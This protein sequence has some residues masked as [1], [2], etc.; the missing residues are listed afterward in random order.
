MIDISELSQTSGFPASKL[1]YYEEVGLIRSVGRRGIKRLYENEVQDRVSLIALAQ[2]GGFSLLEIKQM[3]GSEGR[4]TLDRS[5]LVEKADEL[6]AKIKR[7]ANLSDG[8]RHI[9]N[10]QAE[11]H[12]D[13]PRFQR[14]MKVAITKAER[15]RQST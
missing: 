4:A 2:M 14:I 1:R 7:L 6:D 13:C 8:I 12:L 15:S 5:A 10:C 11:N 9:A 3:I